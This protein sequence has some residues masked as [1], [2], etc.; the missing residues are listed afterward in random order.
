MSGAI[1]VVFNYDH[2]LCDVYWTRVMYTDEQTFSN[3][4]FFLSSNLV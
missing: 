2:Q 1:F 3:G 4:A